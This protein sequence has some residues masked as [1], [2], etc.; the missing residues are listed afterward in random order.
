MLSP[1]SY[2]RLRREAAGLSIQSAASALAALPIA[3]GGGTYRARTAMLEAMLLRI[4]GNLGFL[5]PEQ[6]R[7][8][9]GAFHFDTKVYEELALIHCAGPGCGLPIPQVCHTCG[10]SWFDPCVDG[11]DCCGWSDLNP[12]LCTTCEAKGADTAPSH[13]HSAHQPHAQPTGREVAL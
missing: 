1:G 13:P 9:A 4:E 10:C 8:V 6:A 7:I 2:L 3:V 5:R 12:Q 11:V